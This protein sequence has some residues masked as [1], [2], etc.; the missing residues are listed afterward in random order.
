MLGCSSND[1][2]QDKDN[3]TMKIQVVSLEKCGAT[4]QTISLVKEVAREMGVEIN[5]EH[6]IVKT[7]EDAVAHRHIGSPT[8]QINGLDIDPGAREINQFGIT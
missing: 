5:F 4:P 7:S 3:S 1:F 8:V 6:F 2:A